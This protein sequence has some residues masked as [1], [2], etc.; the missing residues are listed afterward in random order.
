MTTLVTPSVCIVG[1]G[2]MGV[3]T[4]YH[5]GLAGAS[6]TF[7]VRPHRQAQSSRPRCST[8]MTTTA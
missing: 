2:S 1:A 5:L 7:L 3:V 6:V 8:P 4:G